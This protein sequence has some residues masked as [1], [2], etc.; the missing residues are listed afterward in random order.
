MKHAVVLAALLALAGSAAQA[1]ASPNAD[2]YRGGWESDPGSGAPHVLEFSIR[3]PQ[4]RGIYCSVCHD[5]STLAFIDGSLGADGLTFTITHVRDDGSTAFVDH[6]SAQVE[7]GKLHVRG[8]S[9]HGER[10]D[11]QL[12]KDPRGP[13]PV[14]GTPVNRLPAGPPV[15]AP[16]RPAGAAA[17]PTPPP[18]QP[19]GPWETLTAAKVAGAW[20]GF[21]VGIDKQFFIFR[22]VGNQLRG[23]VCGRCDNPYTM[24]AIDDVR[25]EGDTLHFNILHEDWGPGTL[26]SHNQV[27][28]QI[29]Q[30][31]MRLSTELNNTS[32]HHVQGFEVHASL[33]GPVSAEA[34]HID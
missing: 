7:G 5:A 26:P 9:G 29:S 20:L 16:A 17:R 21:G 33:L 4:V 3:A 13:A 25:I 18:Y 15:M 27:T 11:W 6:A 19:P 32:A 14:P 30:N 23:M 8:T 22:R 28:A 1:A 31:E 24:A 12:R 10:I 2:D 34:T